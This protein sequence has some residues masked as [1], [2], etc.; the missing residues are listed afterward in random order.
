MHDVLENGTGFISNQLRKWCDEKSIQ[1]HFIRSE[2][3]TQNAYIESDSKSM[4][5][6]TLISHWGES[7]RQFT[8]NS[9]IN[10]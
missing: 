2:K 3:P 8:V 6:I 10:L 5:K 4:M 1:L 7:P 9:R